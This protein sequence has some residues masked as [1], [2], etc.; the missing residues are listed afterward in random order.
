MASAEGLQKPVFRSPVNVSDGVPTA[1]RGTSI[2]NE[3][4]TAV[5]LV[6]SL[7]TPLVEMATWSAPGL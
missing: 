5:V 1:P 2:A 3:D 7:A 4:E 6:V